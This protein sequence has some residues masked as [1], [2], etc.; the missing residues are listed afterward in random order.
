M[1]QLSRGAEHWYLHDFYE[2]ITD[3]GK[4]ESKTQDLT[5]SQARAAE[6]PRLTAFLPRPRLLDRVA[7]RLRQFLGQGRRDSQRS[8]IKGTL[9]AQ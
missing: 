1:R 5:P 2:T 3:P 8:G 9:L 4:V 6:S 7:E